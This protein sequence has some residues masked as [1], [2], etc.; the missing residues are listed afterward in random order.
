MRLDAAL[1]DADPGVRQLAE[2][3]RWS[4]WFRADTPENNQTLQT[5]IKLSGRGEMKQAEALATHLISVCARLRRGVQPA[6]D[7]RLLRKAA[8]PK[9][10]GDCRA[11]CRPSTPITSALGGLCQCQMHLRRPAEALDTLAACGEGAALNTGLRAAI[12]GPHGRGRGRR[13]ALIAAQAGT[14]WPTPWHSSTSDHPG[15]LDGDL[16][17]VGFLEKVGMGA[18]HD[19][20]I[21]LRLRPNAPS[22]DRA[23]PGGGMPGPWP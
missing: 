3:V 9:S 4:V 13:P 6:G 15:D 14:M 2:A 11:R 19:P 12:R 23:R 1:G 8:T 16:P 20:D 7:H 10:G 21:D 18:C 22:R 5:V 17:D